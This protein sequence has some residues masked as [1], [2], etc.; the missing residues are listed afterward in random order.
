MTWSQLMYSGE[1]KQIS[2]MMMIPIR[3]ITA[4]RFFWKRSQISLP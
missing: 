3:P 1:V 2:I 4:S